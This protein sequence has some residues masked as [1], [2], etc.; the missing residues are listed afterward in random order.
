MRDYG[1]KSPTNFMRTWLHE[2]NRC[3][4]HGGIAAKHENIAG[5]ASQNIK[6]IES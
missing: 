3:S 1:L 6:I 2:R 5:I 4:N